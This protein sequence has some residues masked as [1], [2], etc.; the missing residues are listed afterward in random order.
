LGF[1]IYE[2]DAVI[3]FVVG[4]AFFALEAL[5]LVRAKV[6]SDEAV[7]Q[8]VLTQVSGS[9]LVALCHPVYFCV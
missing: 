5:L 6:C 7:G 8:V 1:C 3:L 4:V 2:S 9:V